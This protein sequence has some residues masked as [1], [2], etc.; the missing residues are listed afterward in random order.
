MTK[1][2]IWGVVAIVL[3][4]GLVLFIQSRKGETVE[5]GYTGT[6]VSG[7]PTTTSNTPVSTTPTT[8]TTAQ[9]S[10]DLAENETGNFADISQATLTKSGYVV[11]YKTNSNGESAIIGHSDLLT[12]GTHSN[13][14]I[15]ITPIA[16]KQAIVAV[17]HQDDGDGKFEFPGA[18][19]YLVNSDATIVS[20][21]DVVDVTGDA[22]E[23]AVLKSQVNTYLEN[24]FNSSSTATN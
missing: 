10:V 8:V 17:L 6:P 5:N 16:Y 14:R 12:A 21:I 22:K 1:N 13:L 20:D 15:Q 19:K 7:Q 9:N 24:H 11:L 4:I 23:D 2:I 3:I 18:D